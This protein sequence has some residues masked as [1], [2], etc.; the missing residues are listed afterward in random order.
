MEEVKITVE[1]NKPSSDGT[2]SRIGFQDTELAVNAADEE[3][4]Q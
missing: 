2:H 3:K 1:T 4:G